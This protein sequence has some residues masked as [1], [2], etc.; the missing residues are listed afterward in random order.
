MS[1][2]HPR[3]GDVT[4][5]WPSLGHQVSRRPR[6]APA[7][8]GEDSEQ[9]DRGGRPWGWE[10]GGIFKVKGQVRGQEKMERMELIERLSRGQVSLAEATGWV[11]A[12]DQ[13]WLR[14]ETRSC[15]HVRST[16]HQE[17]EGSSK[18]QK[19]GWDDRRK[20]VRWSCGL[21]ARL[22]DATG[23]ETTPGDRTRL[24]SGPGGPRW[25]GDVWW[26]WALELPSWPP[27]GEAAPLLGEGASSLSWPLSVS[28]SFCE[29]RPTKP[30]SPSLRALQGVSDRPA[31][32]L[33]R[34]LLSDW[35]GN[36]EEALLSTQP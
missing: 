12:S 10:K 6:G 4:G 20:L 11:A 21:T 22:C 31:P 17:H 15:S 34:R 2:Q 35:G 19:Q 18:G 33:G 1:W 25:A 36:L 32:F 7:Q 14:G 3:L 27:T 16:E 24:S 13:A 23:A 28:T 30:K 5:W 29:K 26:L 8:R 9:G